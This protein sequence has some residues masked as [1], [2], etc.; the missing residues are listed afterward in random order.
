MDQMDFIIDQKGLK[1]YE[2]RQKNEV[3]GR[4]V[5]AF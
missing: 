2:N 1:M 5:P 4:K 3:F